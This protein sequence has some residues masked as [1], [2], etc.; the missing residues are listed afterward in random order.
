[1]KVEHDGSEAAQGDRDDTAPPVV[2]CR[3]VVKSFRRAGGRFR[4]ARRSRRGYPRVLDGVSL[5]IAAGEIVGLVGESGSG[6]TTLGKAMLKLLPIDAGTICLEGRDITAMKEAQLRPL[7]RHYQMIFQNPH[8]SLNPGMK[9]I[10]AVMETATLHLGLRG[11]QGYDRAMAMLEKV[12]LTHRA[13]AWPSELSGGEKRRVGLARV[14]MLDPRFVVADE[15]TA[16]LD[17]SLKA[18]IV[19][20]MLELKHARMSYLLISHDL[21]LVRYVSDRIDVM[22]RGTIVESI[23]R[24]AFDEGSEHHPYTQRLLASQSSADDSGDGS[25]RGFALERLSLPKGE[26]CCYYAHCIRAHRLGKKADICRK[27]PPPFESVAGGRIACHFVT[28]GE[29]SSACPV[30]VHPSKG[31]R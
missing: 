15:P 3:E 10:D 12:R 24:G 11:R 26:G 2:S 27:A 22:F 30:H 6:K 20:L 8:A 5:R 14:F 25:A 28:K 4:P 13:H 1:M 29:S 21:S 18:G 19:R 31:V 17:A 7:R 16:G 23:E 9:V